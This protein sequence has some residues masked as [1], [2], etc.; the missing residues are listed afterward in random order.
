MEMDMKK[1]I[2]SETGKQVFC[3]DRLKDGRRT[4]TVMGWN[5]PHTINSSGRVFVKYGHDKIDRSYFPHVFGMKFVDNTV[6]QIA[7]VPDAFDTLPA[8]R[9]TVR[10]AAIRLRKKSYGFLVRYEKQLADLKAEDMPDTFA[11]NIAKVE[12]RIATCK[13]EIEDFDR[14]I[15][16]LTDALLKQ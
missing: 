5:E 14:D 12:Q 2:Y 10:A 6:A 7:E 15:A 8:S 4:V 11:S 3:G 9:E 13:Q 16:A 1:L